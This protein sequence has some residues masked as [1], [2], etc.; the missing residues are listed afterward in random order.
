MQHDSPNKSTHIEVHGHIGLESVPDAGAGK[1]KDNRFSSGT[2]CN[3]AW[4]DDGR[5]LTEIQKEDC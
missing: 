3:A 1:R 2:S 4:L 5:P